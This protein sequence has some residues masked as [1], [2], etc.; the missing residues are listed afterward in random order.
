MRTRTLGRLSTRVS[1]IIGLN[2][3][4]GP[5]YGPRAHQSLPHDPYISGLDRY[6]AKARFHMVKS[7]ARAF[8]GSGRNT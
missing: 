8:I 2:F 7:V 6:W 4:A 5:S 1:R 3:I